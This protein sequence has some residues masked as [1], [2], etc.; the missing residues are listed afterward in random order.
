MRRYKLIHIVVQLF[1]GALKSL[2]LCWLK[3]RVWKQHS[4]SCETPKRTQ[5]PLSKTRW[6]PVGVRTGNSATSWRE[7]ATPEFLKVSRNR[8]AHLAIS[9]RAVLISRKPIWSPVACNSSVMKSD[10]ILPF[11]APFLTCKLGGM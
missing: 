3:G 11:C 4:A 8:G 6:F 10:I 1:L 9:S 2:A 5:I 7:S